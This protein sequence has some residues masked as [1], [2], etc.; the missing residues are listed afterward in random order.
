MSTKSRG[1]NAERDLVH[2]FWASKW[3]CFRAAG[4]G[5][6]KYPTPDIIA[7]NNIRKLAIE[8]KLTTSDRQY[9]DRKE[10]EDLNLFGQM[11][12]A[13]PWVA[14]KFSKQEWVFLMLED[15]EETPKAFVASIDVATRRG[16]KFEEIVNIQK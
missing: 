1:T 15:L 13:E 4:S 10:I 6:N 3:A 14:I 9:F 16:L 2:K 8:V 12:G 7:G 5:S 11:F